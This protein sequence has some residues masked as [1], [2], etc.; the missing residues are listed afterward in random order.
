MEIQ[1][2]SAIPFLDVLVIKIEERQGKHMSTAR[3]E[4]LLD[5]AFS[6]LS[7]PRLHSEG[8]R[9]SEFAVNSRYVAT[10]NKQT[11]GFV[12]AVVIV[13]IKVCKTVRWNYLQL[14]LSL[15]LIN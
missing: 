10:T 5:A 2:E 3:I 15:C 9:R 12:G 4:E 14:K 8:R 13:I 6:M 11:E 7:V 1:T